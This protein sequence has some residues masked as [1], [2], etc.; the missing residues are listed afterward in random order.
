MDIQWKMQFG[1]LTTFSIVWPLAPLC[2]LINN[3]IELRFRKSVLKCDDPYLRVSDT[4]DPWLENVGF[5]TC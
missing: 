5:L 4:M 1:Y 3:W 2:I